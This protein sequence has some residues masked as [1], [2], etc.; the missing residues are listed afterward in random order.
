MTFKNMFSDARACGS[1]SLAMIVC[2]ITSFT[3]TV[4]VT[5]ACEDADARAAKNDH[6]WSAS[7]SLELPLEVGAVLAIGSAV[8]TLEG[9]I[10][11]KW[12]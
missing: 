10:D 3:S 5:A 12:P 4:I 8:L 7:I 11:A 2:K 1:F 9:N 6:T